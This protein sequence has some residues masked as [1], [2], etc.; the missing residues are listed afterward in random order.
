M[1]VPVF[2]PPQEP[3]YSTS[4]T[5]ALLS[6]SIQL[7]SGFTQVRPINLR[8]V[9][10]FDL[11]W[12]LATEATREYVQSFTH[13]LDGGTGPFTW[14]PQF[15]TVPS[16]TGHLPVLSAVAGGALVG[17]TYYVAISWYDSVSSQETLLSQESSLAVLANKFLSVALPY[18]PNGATHTNVYVGT[19]SGD[20]KR[21]ASVVTRSWTQSV[22]L[23]GTTE[24]PTANN[25]LPAL[26]FIYQPPVQR[27][28]VPGAQ[29]WSIEMSL[30]ESF[31]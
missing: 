17:A 30:L 21:E 31:I 22:A 2:A 5:D 25:L 14:T 19:S 6:D 29:L 3:S 28:P 24:E 12:N 23:A 16:P 8:P 9:R 15:E 20:L 18:R 27:E 10:R 7:H 11:N 13:T 1:T 26:R 4:I